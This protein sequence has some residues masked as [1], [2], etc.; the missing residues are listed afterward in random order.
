MS[1]QHECRCKWCLSNVR[2]GPGD[3]NY[4]R[5]KLKNIDEPTGTL[6]TK[7]VPEGIEFTNTLPDGS[8]HSAILYTFSKETIDELRACLPAAYE[9]LR[10]QELK[11]SWWGR[12]KLWFKEKFK[13]L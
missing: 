13:P 8:K 4:G 9:K 12:M 7:R 6:S 3:D 10:T 11:R 2:C 1:H 5:D